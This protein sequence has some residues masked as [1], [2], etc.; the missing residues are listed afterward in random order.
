MSNRQKVTKILSVGICVIVVLLAGWF[1][2][3]GP[4]VDAY[5][6]WLLRTTLVSD[7]IKRDAVG[8]LLVQ[9]SKATANL[10]AALDQDSVRSPNLLVIETLGG[11][12]D[13]SA[14]APL[15]RV[16]NTAPTAR[17]ELIVWAIGRCG[18]EEDAKSLIPCLSDE[19]PKVR[20][21]V[22]TAIC[23]LAPKRS[24]KVLFDGLQD[25]E[26][27]VRTESRGSLERTFG[28]TFEA[29]TTVSRATRIP[30]GDEFKSWQ[31]NYRIALTKIGNW[32]TTESAK[33][34]DQLEISGSS[35]TK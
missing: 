1:L 20:A 6:I 12:R 15:L 13:H 26:G 28:V 14:V 24:F 35:G 30:D 18:R 31:I 21:R 17:E 25:P 34:P 9:G 19:N 16:L 3:I 7:S 22:I 27:L 10:I 11:I 5:N 29:D 33:F 32:W 8:R 4:K 2:I 23:E